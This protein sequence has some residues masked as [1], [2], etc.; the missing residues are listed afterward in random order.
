M[1]KSRHVYVGIACHLRVDNCS[2]ADYHPFSERGIVDQHGNVT[3]AL[4]AGTVLVFIVT[5]ILC[6][7]PLAAGMHDVARV[8]ARQYV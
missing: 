3:F 2:V 5:I 6:T 8:E 4:L 7:T 1:V